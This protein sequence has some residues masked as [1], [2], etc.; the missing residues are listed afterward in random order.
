MQ[1]QNQTKPENAIWMGDKVG[2]NEIFF[3]YLHKYCVLSS[4]NKC[5]SISEMQ[6]FL[7]INPSLYLVHISV[8]NILVYPL[9]HFNMPPDKKE[10]KPEHFSKKES[11]EQFPLIEATNEHLPQSCKPAMV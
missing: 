7:F 9:E 4:E 6:D 8:Q 3:P 1:K 5:F 2:H 11:T 10:G